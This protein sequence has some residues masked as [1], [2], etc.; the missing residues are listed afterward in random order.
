MQGMFCTME[1]GYN[2]LFYTVEP[3]H[4]ALFY[5]NENQYTRI[6]STETESRIQDLVLCKYPGSRTL[7]CT[8]GA[9]Y[10]SMFCTNGTKMQGLV[11]KALSPSPVLQKKKKEKKKRVLYYTNRTRIQG[12]VKTIIVSLFKDTGPCSV[13]MEQ[14]YSILFYINGD[15]DIGCSSVQI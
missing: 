7:F 15:Q 5:T 4:W 12:F 11:L 6:C 13:Q 9:R 8:I 14:G 3:G 1:K 2:V 10:R